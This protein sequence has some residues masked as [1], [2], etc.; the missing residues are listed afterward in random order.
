MAYRWPILHACSVLHGTRHATQ[1]SKSNIP[2][3]FLPWELNWVHWLVHLFANIHVSLFT[4]YHPISV[5]CI[6]GL[7]TD[8]STVLT[9]L[10]CAIRGRQHFAERRA[11]NA[12]T[13]LDRQHQIEFWRTGQPAFGNKLCRPYGKLVSWS[14]LNVKYSFFGCS[15]L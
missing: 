10:F 2:S 12:L 8:F 13:P 6:L 1:L 14:R 9:D 15:R 11:A 4:N 5:H 7:F 3:G